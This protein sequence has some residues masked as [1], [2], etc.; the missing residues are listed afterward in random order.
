MISFRILLIKCIIRIEPTDKALNKVSSYISLTI[1]GTR[2][3]SKM[4]WAGLT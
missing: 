4:H 2:N 3:K 1:I